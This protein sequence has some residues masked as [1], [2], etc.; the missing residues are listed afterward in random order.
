MSFRPTKQSHLG[1]TRITEGG[2]NYV[3]RVRGVFLLVPALLLSGCLAREGTLAPVAAP[4]APAPAVRATTP[5]AA[6]APAGLPRF[7]YGRAPAKGFP[8]DQAPADLK[9]VTR[10]LTPKRRLAVY[11]APGG[12][13]RAFLPRTVSGLKVTVPIVQTRSG[14]VAV[15]LPTANRRV[16]WLPPGGWTTTALRD[17]IIVRRAQHRL[18]WLRDGRIRASWTVGIGRGRTATPLGR[19]FFFGRTATNGHVYGGLDAL[20]LGAVPDDRSALPAGLRGAHTAIHG[21]YSEASFGRS[22]SNGCV[23]MPKA[24]QRML[25]HYL[26]PGTTVHVLD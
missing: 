13:P 24:A 18:I 19:T 26:I 7:R 6:P 9:H 4:A 10:G 1:N 15:L 25:L 21:W 20:V 11:D 3:L 12:R 17:Q 14:W 2:R 23:R 5:A 16:G 8:A 22:A